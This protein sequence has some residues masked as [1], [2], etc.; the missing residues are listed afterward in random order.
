M[1]RYTSALAGAAVS[2]ALLATSLPAQ[3]ASFRAAPAVLTSDQPVAGIQTVDN[4]WRWRHGRRHRDRD[5]FRLGFGFGFGAPFFG[6]PSYSYAYRP[7]RYSYPACPYGSFWD[8]YYGACVVAHY[9][10]YRTHPYSGAGIG[11]EYR[12][13]G[14]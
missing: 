11:L 13:R 3:A 12:E 8:P 14:F 5:H 7:Y 2:L 4:D 10:R 6:F 9:P 1:Q